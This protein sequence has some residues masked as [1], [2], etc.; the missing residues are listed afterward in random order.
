MHATWECFLFLALLSLSRIGYVI[1]CG[2]NVTGGDAELAIWSN[3]RRDECHK[4][5]ELM[6][7]FLISVLDLRDVARWEGQVCVGRGD[8]GSL[9]DRRRSVGGI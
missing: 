8:E 4:Y 1:C 9:H 2:N 7:C 6:R 5:L 3:G